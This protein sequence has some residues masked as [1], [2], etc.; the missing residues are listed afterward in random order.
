MP[1]IIALENAAFEDE[2]FFSIAHAEA[3]T[4]LVK[5]KMVDAPC[6]NAHY[7]VASTAQIEILF[8][9]CYI[10]IMRSCTECCERYFTPMLVLSRLRFE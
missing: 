2:L 4:G 9:C 3:V 7:I 10:G 8:E 6:G 5:R 1:E